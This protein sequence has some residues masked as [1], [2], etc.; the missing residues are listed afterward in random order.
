MFVLERAAPA[1]APLQ[2]SEDELEQ[3]NHHD[4]ADQENDTNGAA[5]EFQH[6]NALI[7]WA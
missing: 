1:P 6:K 3:G 5:K 4:Q 7:E 2:C